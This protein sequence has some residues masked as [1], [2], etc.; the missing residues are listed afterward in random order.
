VRFEDDLGLFRG[1]AEQELQL[2]VPF[3][4]VDGQEDA[5]ELPTRHATDPDID[6]TRPR[7]VSP[8]GALRS[9][10]DR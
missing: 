3:L 8:L 5:D 7:Q 1:T 9:R 2:A 6:V 10:L 4:E